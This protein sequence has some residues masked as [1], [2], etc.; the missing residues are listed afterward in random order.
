MLSNFV[1]SFSI[2]V[3][4]FASLTLVESGTYGGTQVTLPI[5]EKKLPPIVTTDTTGTTNATGTT[6]TNSTTSALALTNT[7]KICDVE[8][9]TPEVWKA[10]NI[11]GFLSSY[12]NGNNLTL[13]QFAE[14]HG[15]YNFKCGIGDTC[16]AGQICAPIPGPVWHVLYAVQQWHHIQE[17]LNRALAFAANTLIALS[18]FDFLVHGHLAKWVFI[19]MY[20]GSPRQRKSDHLYKVSF[21]LALVVAI[22]ATISA[23]AFLWVPGVNNILI[24]GAI[25]AVGAAVAT[26]QAV[27]TIQ[28]QQA[29]DSMKSDAFSRWAGYTEAITKWQEGMQ[30]QLFD[31]TKRALGLG[32]NDPA[33]LGGV[34]ANGALSPIP[35]KKQLMTSKKLW[36]MSSNKAFV[37][38]NSDECKQ[39]GPNGAFKSEDGWLSWCKDGKMMNIIYAD[40]NKSG[41]K[42]YNGGMIPAKYGITVE[43]MTT[44]S[45]NCQIKY[46]GYGH[47]PYGDGYVSQF[48]F[49]F[50]YD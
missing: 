24:M 28:A 48:K 37:T 17:S 42:L 13:A 19:S 49:K 18:A 35:C 31:D 7:S 39:G 34:L 41:N 6:G 9:P 30:K 20:Q 5:R 43:Y 3:V 10:R 23:A 2:L 22:I 40:G 32:I 21:I 16:D 25:G 15:V 38:V 27:T 11:S 33:G 29:F 14:Q 47:D 1:L 46:G 8:S 26:G 4:L 36:K 44:Q 12:P 45:E 50:N